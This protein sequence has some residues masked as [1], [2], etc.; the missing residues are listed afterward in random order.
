LPGDLLTQF[1]EIIEKRGY[2]SRSEALR[3]AIRNYITTYKWMNEVH[4]ERVGVISL[5][6]EHDQRGLADELTD[7]QH[8]NRK[9]ITASVHVH[10]DD[11]NCLEII[12]LHGDGRTIRQIAESVMALKGVKY[13][14]LNAISPS[15]NYRR[16]S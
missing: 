9:T 12:V 1:D 3:D 16:L 13:V 7:M 14:K 2:S 11:E 6:Y 8:N 15:N 4:G 5:V 10:L